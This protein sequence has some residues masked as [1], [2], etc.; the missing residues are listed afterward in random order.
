MA[1]L[2]TSAIA[3]VIGWL[4]AFKLRSVWW[5]VLALLIAILCVPISG[6]FIGWFAA[7]SIDASTQDAAI[8]GF[9]FGLGAALLLTPLGYYRG[10]RAR[11]QSMGT[12]ASPA[13][14]P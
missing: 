5:V 8:G 11:R 6:F 10:R 3:F 12:S 13:S 4:F 2:V 14:G 1:A 9:G 7:Q